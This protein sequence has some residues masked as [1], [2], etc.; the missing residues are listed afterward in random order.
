MAPIVLISVMK[1]RTVRRK[2]GAIVYALH[3]MMIGQVF[4]GHYAMT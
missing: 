2:I 3:S 1:S 4:L